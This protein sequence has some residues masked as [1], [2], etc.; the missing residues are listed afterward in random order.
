M[1]VA[2]CL[3]W[4]DLW[5]G[6]SVSCTRV[7]KILIDEEISSIGLGRKVAMDLAWIN[8][9]LSVCDHCY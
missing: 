8:A 5:G 2:F 1:V 3:S 6:E 9:S 7:G 4:T